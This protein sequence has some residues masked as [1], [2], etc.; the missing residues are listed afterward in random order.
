MPAR[1]DPQPLLLQ[2]RRPDGGRR[3]PL[4]GGRRDRAHR[5]PRRRT[6]HRSRRQRPRNVHASLYECAEDGGL[7]YNT[8]VCVDR[9]G[10]LVGRTRKNHI[11]AFPGY[12]EDLCFRPGDSGFPV[13]AHQ[14]A[15]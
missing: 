6:G 1:A 10:E 5:P 8:A 7:G 13:V 4:P 12:R 11:P 14:G 9:N 15:G 2:H 3:R